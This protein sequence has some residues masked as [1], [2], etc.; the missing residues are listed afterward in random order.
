M[1]HINH[2][3]SSDSEFCWM[4]SDMDSE[5]ESDFSELG[6]QELIG[7][8]LACLKKELGML[9]AKDAQVQVTKFSSRVYRRVGETLACH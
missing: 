5:S 2:I 9:G 7:S 4:D 8:F 1:D 6:G 3:L